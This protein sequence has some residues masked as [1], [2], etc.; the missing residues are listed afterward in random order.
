MQKLERKKNLKR[1]T[2]WQ[3]TNFNESK[4]TNK[5][6]SSRHNYKVYKNGGKTVQTTYG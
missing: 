1:E 2:P 6:L 3:A 5:I 4:N